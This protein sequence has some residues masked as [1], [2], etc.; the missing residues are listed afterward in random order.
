MEDKNTKYQKSKR[1]KLDDDTKANIQAEDTEKHKIR[2]AQLNLM[3]IQKQRF[4]RKTLH[5]IKRYVRMLRQ[6][7]I[8][9]LKQ[10]KE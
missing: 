8:M 9:H 4:K 7:K 6:L 1:S 10:L 2:R 3:M 5:D